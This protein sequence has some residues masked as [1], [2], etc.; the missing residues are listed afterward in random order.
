MPH[1]AQRPGGRTAKTTSAVF[2]A[3][4]EE[5][6][7]RA[8][9][10][11]SVESIAI[12]AGVHKTTIYR[13]WGSK[14]ELIRQALIASAASNI[15]VPDTGDVERDLHSLSRSVQSL[16]T[17]DLG[18]AVTTSLMAGAASSPEIRDAVNDLWSTRRALM[19]AIVDRAVDHGQ[20]KPG[21][22]ASRVLEAMAAPL[23]YRLLVAG[24]Q[25]TVEDADRSA[26]AAIAAA[27]AGVFAC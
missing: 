22:D 25:P 4:I 8:Y 20:L 5:L 23:Y 7:H 13:R 6:A 24:V 27:R 1:P 18:G 15:D 10:D 21:T 2:D 14:T 11:V 9:A 16:L 3:T 19:A 12:A 17:T 26:A